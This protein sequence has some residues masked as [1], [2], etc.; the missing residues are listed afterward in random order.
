MYSEQ[1]APVNHEYAEALQPRLS[2]ENPSSSSNSKTYTVINDMNTACSDIATVHDVSDGFHKTTNTPTNTVSSTS[3]TTNGIH[4]TCAGAMATHTSSCGGLLTADGN[5]LAAGFQAAAAANVAGENL[6]SSGSPRVAESGSVEA[7][8][9]KRKRDWM[10]SLLDQAGQSENTWLDINGSGGKSK[11]SSSSLL[12]SVKISNGLYSFPA[13]WEQYLDLQTGETY[14]VNW[15]TRTKHCRVQCPEVQKCLAGVQQQQR[16]YTSCGQVGSRSSP[17]NNN[18]ESVESWL[19]KMTAATSAL[20]N[21]RAPM[22]AF[23]SK[24]PL[25]PSAFKSSSSNKSGPSLD[26]SIKRLAHPSFDHSTLTPLL[27]PHHTVATPLPTPTHDTHSQMFRDFTC[28]S[29]TNELNTH[30]SLSS[31]SLNS[32]TNINATFENASLNQLDLASTSNNVE[33]LAFVCSN[34]NNL[35]IIACLTSLQ[36]PNCNHSIDKWAHNITSS[37]CDMPLK[38]LPLLETTGIIK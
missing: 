2:L 29:P 5:I 11:S 21:S 24:P 6:A 3:T 28:F 17:S 25:P 22:A 9:C 37:A 33:P 26:L 7:G 27:D 10:N 8:A 15:N 4:T 12:T 14:Y 38:A 13:G 34:C 35:V 20:V 31:I 19:S 30:N 18:K 36:C 16:P 1:A 32:Y 23:G